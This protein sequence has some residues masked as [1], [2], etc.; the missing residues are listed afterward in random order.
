VLKAISMGLTNPF[1][2]G[3]GIASAAF[4]GVMA[5]I[6]IPNSDQFMGVI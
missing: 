6:Q 4:F 1:R 2:A 5:Y 3:I